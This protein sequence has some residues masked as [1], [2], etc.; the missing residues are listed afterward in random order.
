[1]VD[2]P[3]GEFIRSIRLKRGFT[4]V[5][6]AKRLGVSKQFWHDAERDRRRMTHLPE[7]AEMLEIDLQKLHEVAGDCPACSGTGRFEEYKQT[8][9]KKSRRIVGVR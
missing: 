2:V 1:M 5:E 9:K 4:V 8:S 6:C 3:L 7:I